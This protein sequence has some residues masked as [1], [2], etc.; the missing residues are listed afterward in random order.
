MLSDDIHWANTNYTGCFFPIG[1]KKPSPSKLQAT[2][3]DLLLKLLTGEKE[4]T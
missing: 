3:T 2:A 4:Q 1:A